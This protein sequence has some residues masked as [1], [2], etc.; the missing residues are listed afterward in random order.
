MLVATCLYA[1]GTWNNLI[2]DGSQIGMCIATII[3]AVLTLAEVWW[4]VN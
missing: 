4:F 3:I 2:K 1:A